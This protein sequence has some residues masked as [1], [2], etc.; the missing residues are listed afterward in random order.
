MMTKEQVIEAIRSVLRDQLNH[1]HLDRFAPEARLNE[2]LYLDSV[3]ILE[4]FLALELQF[5]LSAPEEAINRQDIATVR[6]SRRSCSP[7][8]PVP[9]SE[10]AKAEPAGEGVHGEDY[11]DIKVHCFVSSVCDALKRSGIDQRPFYFGVWD[12]DFAIT[13]RWAARL[14]PRLRSTTS[15]SAPGT[16]VSTASRMQEWYDRARSKD[17]N[18]VS[19]A[20]P[21]SSAGATA[22]T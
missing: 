11:I 18:V 14:S 19:H 6:G 16:S 13:E 9:P 22:S 1:A 20:R 15:S 2:D 4:I 17:E 12:A 7:V 21:A 10:P 3:L 8:T 5:G